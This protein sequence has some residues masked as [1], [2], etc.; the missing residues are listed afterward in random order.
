MKEI[1]IKSKVYGEFL[2]QVDDEDYE[3]LSKYKMSINFPS[4]GGGENP[5]VKLYMDKKKVSIHRIIMQRHLS[6]VEKEC[7]DHIDGNPLNNQK[8]NLRYCSYWEN[9]LNASS[10]KNSSSQ[11]RGVSKTLEGNWEVAIIING[12]NKS[13]RVFQKERLAAIAY[14]ILA[15]KRNGKFHR[16]NIS[17]ATEDEINKVKDLM[18]ESRCLGKTSS[19]FG[20]YLNKNQ[21]SENWGFQIYAKSQSVRKRKVGFK[22][23]FLAA[24]ARDEY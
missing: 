12:K 8:E 2:C 11:Y 23:S 15:K 10:A 1:L 22:S 5:Y 4:R 18:V 9:T 20:V 24:K 3:W 7:V 13:I 17:D 19:Y 21:K 14:D 16:K 6:S